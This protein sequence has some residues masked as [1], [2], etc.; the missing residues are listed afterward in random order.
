MTAASRDYVTV[1][2]ADGPRANKKVS[3]D[4]TTGAITK[5]AAVEGGSYIGQTMHVLDAE[6]MATVLTVIGSDPR[7]VLSCGYFQDSEAGDEFAVWSRKKIAR[8]MKL[9]PDA[10]PRRELAERTKGW[11]DFGGPFRVASR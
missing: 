9:N 11:H 5:E 3:R 2:K 4:P 8:A 1:F 10:M 6:A 7:M